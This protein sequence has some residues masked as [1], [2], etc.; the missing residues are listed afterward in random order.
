[1]PAN[2]AVAVARTIVASRLKR[3]YFQGLLNSMRDTG[4]EGELRS[5]HSCGMT[6]S[7]PR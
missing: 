7:D 1:M 2:G 5:L 3:F 4:L 6:V